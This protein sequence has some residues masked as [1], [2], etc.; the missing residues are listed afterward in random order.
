MILSLSMLCTLCTVVQSRLGVLVWDESTAGLALRE[1]VLL[2]PE[3]ARVG[4]TAR[5]VNSQVIFVTHEER[6]ECAFDQTIWWQQ[7]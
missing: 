5:Q 3:V 7:S 2:E 4:R 6:L 1:V